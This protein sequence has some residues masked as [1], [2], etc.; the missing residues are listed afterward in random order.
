[1]DENVV[2][3]KQACI[4]YAIKSQA[5]GEVTPEKVLQTAKDFYGWVSEPQKTE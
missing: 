1:M 5:P 3:A 2:Y 4:D